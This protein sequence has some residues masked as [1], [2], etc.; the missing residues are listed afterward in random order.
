[1]YDL[2]G[3]DSGPKHAALIKS[4]EQMLYARSEQNAV[5][6]AHM[7]PIFQ[8]DAIPQGLGRLLQ[9]SSTSCFS[10]SSLIPIGRILVGQTPQ[11]HKEQ[12]LVKRQQ[13]TKCEYCP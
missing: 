5:A 3:Q 11:E 1:M 8:A 7:Q 2:K 9:T 4:G 13:A 12:Y 6:L 10:E